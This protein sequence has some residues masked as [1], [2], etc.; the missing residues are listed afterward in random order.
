M[1]EKGGVY[2]KATVQYNDFVG[3]AAADIR[4]GL[5]LSEY[6]MRKGVDTKRYEPIGA[7]FFSGEHFFRAHII[8]VDKFAEDSKKAVKFS[9]KEDLSDEEFF[10]LFKRF[11]VIITKKYED[12]QNW[13]LNDDSITI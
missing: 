9:F 7:E 13:E 11:R 3:T 8:C 6:I 2:M 10:G 5:D 1:V 4:D 12:Y